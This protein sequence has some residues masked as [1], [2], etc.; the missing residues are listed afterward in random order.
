MP[1]LGASIRRR[2][3]GRVSSKIQ[4]GARRGVWSG[5]CLSTTVYSMVT[6]RSIFKK[7]GWGV[8]ARYVRARATIAC[9]DQ[10][11]PLAARLS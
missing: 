10:R 3:R 6:V 4:S 11:A 7:P 5:V 2:Q 9:K 8:A 1:D